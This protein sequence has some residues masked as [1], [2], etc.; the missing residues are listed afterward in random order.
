MHKSGGFTIVE[1]IIVCI[2]IGILAGVAT[3]GWSAT[4]VAGRDRTRQAEQQDWLKRFETYRQRYNI[5]P[6][7]DDTGTAIGAGD[8]CLGTGFPSGRCKNTATGPAENATG[9]LMTQLAKVGTLP[10]YK[11]S[12]VNSYSGPWAQYTIGSP[13]TIRIYQVYESSGCPTNT[14]KDTS[15]TGATACYAILTRS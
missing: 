3:V 14:T 8:Y 11:H 1:L 5:Y 2:V 9:T 15:I 4:L 7:T 13:N 6:D 10:D 12:A